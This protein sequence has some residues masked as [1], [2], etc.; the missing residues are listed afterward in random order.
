MAVKEK[1]IVVSE[2]KME[3]IEYV[4]LTLLFLSL[5][6]LFVKPSLIGGIF[7]AMLGRVVPIVVK[8]YL[9]GT[10]GSAIILSVMTGRILERLGFTDALVRVFT[11]LAKIFRITPLVIVPAIYNILGDI[12]ASGRITAPSL[13]KAEAT[14][15]EQ[16]I[17]IAT[18]CQGNQSFS[19]FML[20]LL[21]FTKGGIWAFPIIVVGLFLPVILVPFILSKTIYRNVKYKDISEMPRFT[22][23]T[24]AVPTIF[25][26][27]REGAEL[28]FLL[29]IPAA[30]VVFALIGA[31]DFVGV[32]K[33]IESAISAF[34]SAL[35]IDPKT[36]LQSVLVSPT[37]AMNTLVET[38][39]NVPPRFA[40]GSFI[41]A[42]S[43]FPLQ[44]PLAQIP[45]VWAQNS[46]L[47]A[48]EAMQASIV[49]MIIRI[50]SAFALAWIL[51]PFVA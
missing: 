12:N 32:W 28:L 8:V 26:G 31:L 45:A 10:L 2:R 29:L 3:T 34:L 17:A 11:P 15:D 1:E 46:D 9:T 14:K 23:N 36:G 40:I 47:S 49:G 18:M 42:A 4:G 30:A 44:I 43:G 48:G 24:P 39:K 27:A 25:N 33:P 16:K 7:D 5:I 41:I 50:I 19:T 37:L 22:P 20:G 51:A 13:K 35:S 38:I 21:A 6:I